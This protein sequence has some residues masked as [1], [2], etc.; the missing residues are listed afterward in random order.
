[1]PRLSFWKEGAHS[2]DYKFQDKIISEQFQVGGTSMS[3]HK[4]LGPPINTPTGDATQPSYTNQS[5]LNIQDLLFLE[6]RDRKYEPDIYILR[7][8]YQ[9]A[10]NDFD[11]SQFGLFLANGTIFINFHLNDMVQTIGRKLMNG[12]VLEIHHLKD[13]NTLD[14]TLPIALRRYYV[15][16]DAKWPTEGFTQTWWPHLW[17]VKCTPMVNAQEYKDILD[18]IAQEITGNANANIF[19]SN[20]TSIM[21]TYDKLTNIN[22]AVILQAE[23][24]VP[25]SGY[26][27]SDLY[28]LPVDHGLKESVS[29]LLFSNIGSGYF[30]SNV[31][32]TFSAPQ[33]VEG[34][35][36][37]GNVHLFGNGAIANVTMINQGYGY[38]EIPT[39]TFTG[40]N[41]YPAHATAILTH[42]DNPGDPRVSHPDWGL[43]GYLTGDGAPPNGLTAQAGISFPPDAPVG[44][45]FLRVDF[46]PNRLFRFDGVRWNKLEDAVRANLSPGYN[47]KTLISTFVNNMATYTDSNGNTQPS[48]QSL[49]T[50]FR[51]SSD[52]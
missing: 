51:L 50:I 38:T 35:L 48:K 36:P 49:H 47:N 28:V 9:V 21:T 22:D 18:Q 41:T 52:N 1:M 16:Q 12:D 44:T 2:F 26:D 42:L 24:I 32:I 30:A 14:S 25:L 39:V 34:I 17:R 27:T 19:N 8:I 20:I 7:G 11:L 15:V 40:A 10:D 29:S 6:N 5:E 37:V 13:F 33:L 31:G 3:C 4:Y 46:I 43:S 45:Y 23:N